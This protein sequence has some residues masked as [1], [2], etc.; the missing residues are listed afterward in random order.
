MANYE[1]AK[2]KLTNT[3]LNKFNLLQKIRPKQHYE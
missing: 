1:E 3:Q 2:I